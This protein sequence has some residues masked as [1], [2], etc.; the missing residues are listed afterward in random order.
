MGVGP[1]PFGVGRAV[2]GS[3]RSSPETPI[4]PL[5]REPLFKIGFLG[6]QRSA[7]QVTQP[8]MIPALSVLLLGVLPPGELQPPLLSQPSLP[9]GESLAHAPTCHPHRQTVSRDPHSN[10]VDRNSWYS[11]LCLP[12]EPLPRF[13]CKKRD[14]GQLSFAN[15]GCT[16]QALAH[17]GCFINGG[18]YSFLAAG[19]LC[20]QQQTM[21]PEEGVRWIWEGQGRAVGFGHESRIWEPSVIPSPRPCP[22][23]VSS[24]TQPALPGGCVGTTTGPSASPPLHTHS[25]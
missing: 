2:R 12:A 15:E 17:T 1:Q 24:R 16:S 5:P 9:A 10:L 19:P 6:G 14:S 23:R 8:G 7:G 25:C 21:V 22:T 18:C 20:Q 13:P 11:A 4:H 3:V